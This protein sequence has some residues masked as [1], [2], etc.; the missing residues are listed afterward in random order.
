MSFCKSY[1][2]H[3]RIPT[4]FCVSLLLSP[5]GC[6]LTTLLAAP[7]LAYS[8]PEP[9]TPSRNTATTQTSAP[10][11]MGTLAFKGRFIKEITLLP[12][13]EEEKTIRLQSPDATLPLAPGEY[14]WGHVTLQDGDSPAF[15]GFGYFHETFR[16]TAGQTTTLDIGGPLHHKVTAYSS[17]PVIQLGHELLGIG[18]ESYTREDRR[19]VP[20]FTAVQDG[21][22]ID[23]GKFAY[24]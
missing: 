5:T 20:Q 24:G 11:G 23:S 16:I 4:L 17:G 19:E 6:L 7:G 8:T 18:G 13:N 2:R 12:M 9:D 1:S 15:V 14:H 3:K 22:E 10:A 21:R